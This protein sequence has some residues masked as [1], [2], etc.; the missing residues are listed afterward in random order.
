MMFAGASGWNNGGMDTLINNM[1]NY[2]QTWN[3]WQGGQ[4][5]TWNGFGFE[6]FKKRFIKISSPRYW[7]NV[8]KI[9]KLL[10]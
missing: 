5:F 2:G 7:N 3:R 9:F 10:F 6:F 1:R 4:T 8:L